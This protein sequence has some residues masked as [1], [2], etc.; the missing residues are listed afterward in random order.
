MV[1]VIGYAML[2]LLVVASFLLIRFS[3]GIS[4]QLAKSTLKP[5]PPPAGTPDNFPAAP[6]LA[7]GAI[8]LAIASVVDISGH[9]GWTLKMIFVALTVALSYFL[10][11]HG[12]SHVKVIFTFLITIFLSKLS[13]LVVLGPWEIPSYASAQPHLTAAVQAILSGYPPWNLGRRIEAVEPFHAPGFL[14][15]IFGSGADHA[16]FFAYKVY[17]SSLASWAFLILGARA[18]LTRRSTP[19]TTGQ[20]L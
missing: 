8:A 19:S 6:L 3:L 4:I 18:G 15:I 12:T 20:P 14:M 7:S 17:F 11:L 5:P 2:L 1:I 9:Y 10:C 16:W 13:Y